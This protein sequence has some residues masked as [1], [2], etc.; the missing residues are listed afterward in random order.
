MKTLE[1][2][3]REEIANGVLNISGRIETWED[4]RVHVYWHPSD[5][6]GATIDVWIKGD[7]V[8]LK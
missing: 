7:T 6:N 4:G 2:K 1:E 5:R 8:T 3:L